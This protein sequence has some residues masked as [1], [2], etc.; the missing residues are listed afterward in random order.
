M[1]FHVI[2]NYLIS[3]ASKQ[4]HGWRKFWNIHARRTETDFSGKP[5]WGLQDCWSPLFSCCKA[6]C[7]WIKAD[8][9]LFSVSLMQ[10][11][12]GCWA[13]NTI[14]VAILSL[15]FLY[16]AVIA[17]WANWAWMLETLESVA[18]LNSDTTF[19]IW[20]KHWLYLRSTYNLKTGGIV[21]HQNCIIKKIKE[22]T[23]KV[24]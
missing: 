12:L 5:L 14:W 19:W 16:K 18:L 10:L 11:V 21:R 9:K 22:S 17:W 7:F 6:H 23:N 24:G 13:I 3:F 20:S 1:Q 8:S 15:K 2:K 4:T